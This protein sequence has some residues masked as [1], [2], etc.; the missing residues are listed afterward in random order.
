[1]IFILGGGHGIRS[2]GMPRMTLANAT[3]REPQAPQ[4]SKPADGL[5]GINGT[6]WMKSALPADPRAE[7]QPVAANQDQEESLHG[8]RTVLQKFNKEVRRVSVLAASAAVRATT[9]ISKP[10]SGT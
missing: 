10:L 9:T 7:N 4:N 2:A 8:W 1:M 6:G 5:F 3:G